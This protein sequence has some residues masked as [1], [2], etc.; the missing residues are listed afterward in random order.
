MINSDASVKRLKGPS[1]PVQDEDSRALVMEALR[2]V[3]LVVI[4]DEDTPLE[5]ITAIQPD[6]LVKGADYK[7]GDVVGGDVVTGRGGRIALAPLVDGQS[8]TA[9]IA[10]ANGPENV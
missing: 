3:D 9:A 8:T 2:F 7:P 10:R 4:F 6:V 1:R 5:A